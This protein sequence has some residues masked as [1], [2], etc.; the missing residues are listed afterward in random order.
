[1]VS[2]NPADEQL[3]A[4]AAQEMTKK[5]G[6][7]I[8]VLSMARLEAGIKQ[9][10]CLNIYLDNYTLTIAGVG[11][12]EAELKQLIANNLLEHKVSMLGRIDYEAKSQL[13]ASADVFCLPS[14]F[15]SFGMV[16][17]E[18][19]AANLPVV[20]LNYQ[21]IPNVV[22][23]FAGKLIVN[24]DEI[25]LSDAIKVVSEMCFSDSDIKSSEFVMK[26]I[27]LDSEIKNG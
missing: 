25:S 21:A 10:W 1:M 17:I 27:L 11:A 26:N 18:A 9:F 6:V 7:K 19:M 13:L 2:P 20:A 16:H 22:P 15:D 4:L 8:Q 23:V 24:D 12:Q 5:H 14:K 3:E